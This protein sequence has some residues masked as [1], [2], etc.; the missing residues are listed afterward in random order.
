MRRVVLPTKEDITEETN[1]KKQEA[2]LED[3]APK[4]QNKLPSEILQIIKPAL[5]VGAFTGMF[6]PSIDLLS[7]FS[8]TSVI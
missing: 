2:P 6:S 4:L 7:L 8:L 5:T 1:S 3:E